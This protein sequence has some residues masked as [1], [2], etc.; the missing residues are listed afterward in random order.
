MQPR[1]PR[2]WHHGGPWR[3]PDWP[4][5]LPLRASSASGSPSARARSGPGPGHR[6]GIFFCFVYLPR[7]CTLLYSYLVSLPESLIVP[8]VPGFPLP[9]PRLDSWPPCSH[10][11]TLVTCLECSVCS[12]S[13]ADAPS[14]R[15]AATSKRPP[16]DIAPITRGPSQVLASW[17]PVMQRPLL[18]SHLRSRMLQPRR[19]MPLVRAASKGPP[20]DIAPITR[21]PLQVGHQSSSAHDTL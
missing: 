16:T 2:R 13:P 19:P 21:G 8:L 3:R 7:L 4:L 5:A 20:T 10:C 6:G 14:A 1:P 9:S 15:H 17:A 18:H 11:F 12:S